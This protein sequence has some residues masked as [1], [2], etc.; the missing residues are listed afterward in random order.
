MKPTLNRINNDYMRE[1]DIQPNV[2]RLMDQHVRP[3]VRN[4]EHTPHIY[5]LSDELV[6]KQH[7]STMYHNPITG[8]PASS[9]SHISSNR[10]PRDFLHNDQHSNVK[11]RNQTTLSDEGNRNVNLHRNTTNENELK[12]RNYHQ[13]PIIEPFVEEI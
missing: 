13:R 2:P 9:N 6:T 8:D 4:N 1:S 12:M 7:P 11:P 3:G 10:T 5:A